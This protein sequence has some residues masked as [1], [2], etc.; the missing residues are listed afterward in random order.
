[1]Y[2]FIWALDDKYDK[3]KREILNMDPIS[4]ARKAYSLVRQEA[5]NEKLMNPGPKAPSEIGVGLGAFG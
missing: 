3:I 4:T 5:V 2:Q 1:M